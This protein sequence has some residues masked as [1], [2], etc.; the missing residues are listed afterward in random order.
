MFMPLFILWI[1][2]RLSMVAII[3][4]MILGAFLIPFKDT[5]LERYVVIEKNV[6]DLNDDDVIAVELIDE[7]IKKKLGISSRKTFFEMELK[8]IKEEARKHN[9]K[10]IL[11]SEHLPKFVP[12]LFI[13]LLV[14]LAFGDAFLWMLSI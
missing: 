6:E 1:Y 4:P 13:S 11:V 5:I 10:K 2:F 14:N 3:I 9:I 12:Y 8:K 7:E